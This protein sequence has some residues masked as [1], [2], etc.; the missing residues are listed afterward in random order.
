MLSNGEKDG[1]PRGGF[2]AQ[3]TTLDDVLAHERSSCPP[4][5]KLDQKMEVELEQQQQQQQQQQTF[6]LILRRASA[7]VQ[8]RGGH[9]QGQSASP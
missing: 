1:C 3:T 6:V 9:P 4:P 2:D 5:S 7:R 8:C